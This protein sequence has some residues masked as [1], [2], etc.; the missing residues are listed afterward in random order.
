ML[1]TELSGSTFASTHQ[2]KGTVQWMAPELVDGSKMYPTM[3]SD[4][5]SFGSIMLQVRHLRVHLCFCP[6]CTC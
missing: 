4:V 1:L 2:G 6:T 3:Q 5:Y